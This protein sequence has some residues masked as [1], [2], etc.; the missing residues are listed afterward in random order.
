MLN[1]SATFRHQTPKIAILNM[2][3]SLFA[4]ISEILTLGFLSSPQDLV[5]PVQH[6]LL[7]GTPL[8]WN[9][10]L[11]SLC[12]YLP[13]R[14]IERECTKN[15]YKAFCEWAGERRGRQLSCCR[16]A[17]SRLSKRQ[18]ILKAILLVNQCIVNKREIQEVPYTSLHLTPYMQA[19]FKCL[20][21]L[22][23][24]KCSIISISGQ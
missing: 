5:G 9:A 21:F 24:F 11:E 8:L 1:P 20:F 18:I 7:L 19:H 13:G 14:L 17:I 16:R 22:K 15:M 12:V 10:N 4:F 23:F 6:L 2:N 3:P